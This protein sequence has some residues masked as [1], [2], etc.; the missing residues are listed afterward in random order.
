MDQTRISIDFLGIR[1]FDR[2][3][4]APF[5]EERMLGLFEDDEILIS[6]DLALGNGEAT[7]WTCDLS[8]EYITING[9][10]RS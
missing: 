1:V 7:I 6:V 8:H 2:G 4:P 5:D 3:L 10:Y 9:S